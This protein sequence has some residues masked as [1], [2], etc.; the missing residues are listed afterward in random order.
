MTTPRQ[1]PLPDGPQTL[2]AFCARALARDPGRP[3]FTCLG[4]TLTYADLDRLSS[5]FAAWVQQELGLARGSRLALMM[6][7]LLQYP[8]ALY[9]LLRAGIAI[10]NVNPLYTPRELEHQLNDSGAE[11]V[12]VFANCAATLEKVV[13]RTA[14][15]HV[16][17]T[18]VGDLV[19]GL[20]GRLLNF[21][22]RHV[23]KAV[24][25]YRLPGHL[26]FRDV[27]ARARGR[28]PESVE[29][30]P[31]DIA[32]LQYTG[33]TTGPSKGAVLT[34]GTVSANLRQTR[35]LQ[36]PV[37]GRDDDVM[38]LPL[39]LYHAAALIPGCLLLGGEGTHLVLIP[40][41]RDLDA[42][43]AAIRGFRLTGFLG[44]NTLFQA[45]LQRDDFR[46]LDWSALR[47]A[48][49]GGA[50]LHQSVAL[51]WH[52][53]TGVRIQ[54][55][56]GLSE[57]SPV[58]TGESPLESEPYTGTVGRPVVGTEIS[59][60]D[61]NGREVARG[62]PGELCARGPQVMAGYLNLPEETRAAFTDDG[63]FRTGD[64]VR[65]EADGNLRIV[66]RKKDMILVSG[67]NVYPNEIENVISLHPCVAEAACVG[68][69]DER[70]GEAA[71]VF[72]VLTDSAAVTPEG[73]LEHCR[74]NLTAY[75]VPK[76]IVFRDELPKT[77]VG[78]ILR[79]E[80]R[81]QA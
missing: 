59:I 66:D 11:A 22:V 56:Y 47:W 64:V 15:K 26:R 67:F 77:P 43:V 55:L 23:K 75:K 12:V 3:A 4:A 49:T 70:T 21:V 78:K 25:A 45:L 46:A 16:I 29:V 44:I 38:V 30:K 17:V 80:L 52:D 53:L 79:R 42:F 40:N 48:A 76:Y 19:P 9:G 20:R 57:T 54:V 39:P 65:E 2:A 51:A 50:P 24:P 63:F 27:M 33:G 74:G 34:H 31:D 61:E 14:V 32:F 6:P 58:L 62:E 60:R 28:R 10:V 41:P 8:V 36:A 71:K 18:E 37:L 13:G 35:A 1:E 5:E 68:V 73:L 72:V 7:N 69:P 81:E